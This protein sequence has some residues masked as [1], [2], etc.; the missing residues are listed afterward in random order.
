MK[1]FGIL[2]SG[3]C[4]ENIIEDGLRDIGVENNVFLIVL[5]R[6]ASSNEDRVFDFILENEADFHAF[7]D[8]KAP[9]VIKDSASRVHEIPDGE[10]MYPHLLKELQK[11]NGTLLMMWN[12]ETADALTE[13]CFEASDMG[14]PVLELTNG[15]IPINTVEPADET[16]VIEETEANVEPFTED[17]LRSMSVG[18]LRKA[19]AAR[20]VEG[21]GAYSKDELLDLLIDSKTHTEKM[22]MNVTYTKVTA[23]DNVVTTR[24]PESGDRETLT[25]PD[26]DCMVTVVMPNGTVISTPATMSEVRVLLGLG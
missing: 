13:I 9:Q 18:V 24:L 15:L 8:S 6:G 7:A 14:I 23:T 26:G 4:G 11:H 1:Y 5:R 21:V 17:E 12:E 16:S 20:G 25:A 19:A 3:S 22:D 10:L 2:G